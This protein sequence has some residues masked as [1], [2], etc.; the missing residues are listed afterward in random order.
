MTKSTLPAT[1]VC[2]I[3]FSSAFA[4]GQYQGPESERLGR[5]TFG[6]PDAVENMLADEYGSWSDWQKS[7][8]NDHG[9]SLRFDYS[10]VFLSAN[11]TSANDSAAGGIARLFGAINF[12]DDGSGALI[13]KVEY[14]HEIGSPS[15]VSF[16]IGE[17]GYVGLQE[18][19]FSDLGLGVT[20]LYWRHRF[21]NGRSTLIAGILDPTDYV[22]VFALG[23]PWLHFMNFA[24]S[25]GSASIGMP[26]DAAVGIA[27]ATMLNKN[28]YIIA[29]ITD[30]NGDPT[31]PFKGFDNFFSNNKYFTSFELGWTSSRNRIMLD[32]FHLTAWRKDRQNAA[33]TSDGYGLAFS[34]SRNVTKNLMPFVRGGY[35][36]DGDSLLQKSLSL[37]IGYQTTAFSGLVG[38]AFNWGEP[39]DD[40]FAPGLEDQYAIEIFYRVPILKRFAI[41]GDVQY[42]KDP[43]L[44]PSENTIWMFNL[45]GRG[46][47]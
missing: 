22:D 47:F 28:M 36:K 34:Y 33:N 46:A 35:A 4:Q 37:G 24:F 31:D 1:L 30:V 38:A 25:T 8:K 29:G 3:S 44:N 10:A 20:N 43:A 39:N 11:D 45:R 6:G 32:N 42:I 41:T 18:R 15:P 13:Y 40:S 23:S 7:L 19:P 9:I 14:R 27:Y 12:S 26:N 16:A 21:R 17:L 2:L 5:P